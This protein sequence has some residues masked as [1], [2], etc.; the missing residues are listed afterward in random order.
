[1]LILSRRIGESVV[2]DGSIEVEVVAIKGDKIK[3]GFVAPRSVPVD[4]KE[5]Y[6]RKNKGK[7]NG[8]A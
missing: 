7:K 3:L 6:T 2:I 5:V 1:M 8:N 4:R